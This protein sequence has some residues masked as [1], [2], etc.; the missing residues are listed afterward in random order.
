MPQVTDRVQELC[1]EPRSLIQGHVL[2]I[3][4]RG[5][6]SSSFR[7]LSFFLARRELT[8]TEE[9]QHPRPGK[10]AHSSGLIAPTENTALINEGSIILL[11]DTARSPIGST[12]NILQLSFVRLPCD[13]GLLKIL[14]VAVGV[15]DPVLSHY[16][17]G[18]TI[19]LLIK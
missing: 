11:H 18:I 9:R 2:N 4:K 1:R 6:R 13:L 14:R 10:C 16:R 8:K 7:C 12:R 5:K 15:V 17:Y 3:H 19:Q